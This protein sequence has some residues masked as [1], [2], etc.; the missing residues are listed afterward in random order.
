[1][2]TAKRRIAALGSRTNTRMSAAVAGAIVTRF[3]S[4]FRLIGD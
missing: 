3:C 1:M 2:A 4:Q